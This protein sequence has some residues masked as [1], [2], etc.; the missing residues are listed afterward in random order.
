MTVFE[1]RVFHTYPIII[2][3]YIL[4]ERF[5]FFVRSII[6]LFAWRCCIKKLMFAKER[7]SD[8]VSEILLAVLKVHEL[9]I[10]GQLDD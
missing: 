9:G 6:F 2:G 7:I 3:F 5:I 10:H 8:V 4:W 1:T